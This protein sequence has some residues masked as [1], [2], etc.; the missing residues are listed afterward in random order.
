MKPT[1]FNVLIVYSQD[2]ADSASSNS[3]SVVVP[4][5]SRSKSEGYNDVYGYFMN[6]CRK[7]TVKVAFTTSADIIGAGLCRSYWVYTKN[8]WIKVK[9]H[10]YAELIFDKFLPTTHTL[11]QKRDLLFS[12]E[13]V[14]SFSNPYIHT[15]FFDKQK[16]YMKL[17]NFTIPTVAVADHTMKSV[18]AACSSLRTLMKLHPHTQD[19]S[20]DI[21]MKDRFGACGNDIYKFEKNQE[22]KMRAVLQKN[23]KKSFIIQPF[24]QFD[25]GYRYN[26]TLVSADIRLIYLKGK[27][28]QT[29]VRMAKKESFLCNEH[30]GGLL[31][32]ITQ[33]DVPRSVMAQAKNIIKTL[34]RNSSLFALDFVISNDGNPYLIEG[35]AEPG[36]DWNPFI[37]KNID[38]S[39]EFIRI[40]VRELARLVNISKAPVQTQT[41]TWVSEWYNGLTR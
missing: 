32:Y 12:S 10:G 33:R 8:V 13:R 29:Y 30:Q 37:Q 11:I 41:R 38:K 34:N 3:P 20:T 35:N 16:T 39:K 40:I 6:V 19:F 27:I 26:N 15:L 23:T 4:F 28:V 36:L 22:N 7:N 24:T 5:N 14:K 21:I 1:L 31:K 18:S 9:E 2:L 25:K 17:K